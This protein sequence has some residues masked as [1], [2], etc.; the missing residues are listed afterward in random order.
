MT[1]LAHLA[2]PP[3]EIYWRHTKPK[4]RGQKMLLRTI[5][6]VAVIGCWY[7]E[8]GENFTAWCPL[9]KDHKPSREGT[10]NRAAA[11]LKASKIGGFTITGVVKVHILIATL[12]S[13]IIWLSLLSYTM[14]VGGFWLVA[15]IAGPV[16]ISALVIGLIAADILVCR[17]SRRFGRRVTKPVPE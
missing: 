11:W 9:P 2:A 16:I 6:G 14:I 17:V 5:G 4:G 13:V 10:A 1:V 15:L 7:G 3:G 12:Y 8:L